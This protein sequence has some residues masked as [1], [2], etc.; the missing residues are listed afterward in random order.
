[1]VI[2]NGGKEDYEVDWPHFSEIT[3]KFAKKGK[4]VITGER[5]RVDG[6]YVV[7]AGSAAILEF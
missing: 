2:L 6:K 4:N 3:G 7:E 1:M 5:V